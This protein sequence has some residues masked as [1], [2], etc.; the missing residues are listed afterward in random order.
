M[1]KN[2]ENNE[3]CTIVSGAVDYGLV[4]GILGF[5]SGIGI[6]TIGF[7]NGFFGPRNKNWRKR[8]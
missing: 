3:L 5:L 1:N 8:K 6:F 4:A 7:L 2:L